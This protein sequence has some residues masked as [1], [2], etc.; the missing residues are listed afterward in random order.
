SQAIDHVSGVRIRTSGALGDRVDIS[1]NGLNGTAVRTYIDGLPLEFVYPNLALNNI[2]LSNV[3]RLDV[4]KGVVPANVGSDALGGAINVVTEYNSR[5]ELSASYSYGSF[6]THISQTK[7][8]LALKDNLIFNFNSSF[9]YSQN[10]YEM[11]AP[12]FDWDETGLNFLNM[13][14]QKV[15]R[16]H[17]S[18]R[19]GFSEGSLIF[20][21]RKWAD[22]FKV[23][24][25]YIDYYKEVQ[26]GVFIEQRAF[27]DVKFSGNNVN[28]LLRY[29][30]SFNN[31]NV[32]ANTVLSDNNALTDDATVNEY[33]WLGKAIAVRD[34]PFAEFN[35]TNGALNSNRDTKGFINRLNVSYQLNESDEILF[36]NLIAIQS[37]SGR[38]QLVANAEEDFLTKSQSLNKNVMGLQLKKMFLSNRLTMLTGVKHYTFW[39]DGVNDNP[40]F[41]R[42]SKTDGF[43]GGYLSLKHK[44]NDA[45]FVRSSAE[46]TYRIPTFFQFFGDGNGIA[47]NEGLKPEFSNNFNLGFSYRYDRLK[48]YTF[49]IAANSFL[50]NQKDLIFLDPENAVPRHI[51]AEEVRSIGAEGEIKITFRE[52]LKLT[53]N[54]TRLRKTFVVAG[55]G[56]AGAVSGQEGKAFPNTPTFF[57]D[58]RLSYET[59]G[60]LKEGHRL[61][62]YI[63]HKFV[64][65]F[66][67]LFESGNADA[68][69]FVPTQRRIDLGFTY[70]I[71]NGR[72][73]L[74]MNVNNVT[75]D[76]LFD[77][78]RV[79]R[80]G[81]NYN[82][83]ITYQINN[84]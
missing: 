73:Q 20:L 8:N 57:I 40:S 13:G 84:F 47:P 71:D 80:P 39:L 22:V 79:P 35:N 17:D 49:Q 61:S 69:F 31:L 16:F 67:F 68:Q 23:G 76:E 36:S 66:N 18:Y 9:S 12:V 30:K 83:R 51:N 2:P 62:V 27:N 70:A 14:I 46:R 7:L 34:E 21:N 19:L 5:N 72:L 44:F 6:N 45:F 37:A 28:V 60:L 11:N 50:R 53:A 52:K 55:N 74:G 63:Q 26:N 58:S 33:N 75:N 54:I 29:E 4:Y 10:N 3:A 65:T 32:S 56:F 38:N 1:I 48:N 64:D 42:F 15:R 81:R 77:N 25:N 82:A 78:F 41:T 59:D 43:F 24:V